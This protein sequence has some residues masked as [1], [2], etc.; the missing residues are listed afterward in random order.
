MDKS[1]VIALISSSYEKDSIGQYVPTETSRNV[2]CNISS[3]TASEFFEAGAVGI[4]PEY[5]VTMFLYDY[6]NEEIAELNGVRYGIYRTYIAQ[7]E[8]IELYL[9]RKA[10]VSS[11]TNSKN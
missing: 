9:E 2:F 5:R 7:N 1:S 4:S 11:G 6:E 10:G 3:V 8:T